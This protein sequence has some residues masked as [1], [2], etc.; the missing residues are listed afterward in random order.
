[1]S[2]CRDCGDPVTQEFE[3]KSVIWGVSDLPLTIPTRS[4]DKHIRFQLSRR[5][6]C[7]EMLIQALFASFSLPI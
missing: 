6:L 4:D 5:L 3:S 7:I 2:G 1:M